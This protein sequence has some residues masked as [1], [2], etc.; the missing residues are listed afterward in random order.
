MDIDYFVNKFE[1]G[2]SSIAAQTLWNSSILISKKVTFLSHR[3]SEY[4]LRLQCVGLLCV[5]LHYPGEQVRR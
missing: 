1:S 4:R 5:R 2:C 3:L